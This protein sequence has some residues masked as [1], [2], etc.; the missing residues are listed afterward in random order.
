MVA[1]EHLGSFKQIVIKFLELIVFTTKAGVH[2]CFPKWPK[3]PT[4]LLKRD[5][6]TGVFL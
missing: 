1:K 2:R 5:S 6:S 3:R 4:T